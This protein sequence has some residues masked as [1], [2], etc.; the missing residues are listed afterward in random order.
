[1]SSL[2]RGVEFCS[3]SG[4]LDDTEYHSMISRLFAGFVRKDLIS[5]LFKQFVACND[6]SFERQ[7]CDNAMHQT[8]KIIRGRDNKHEQF[9][10]IQ[11][12]DLSNEMGLGCLSDDLYGEI[13]SYLKQKDY[14]AYSQTNRAIY[15]GCNS[16]N[17][18]RHLDL[19]KV[20]NYSSVDLSKYPQ[21]R[22]LKIK[23]PK[24]KELKLP[25]NGTSICNH[26]HKLTLDGNKQTDMDLTH[27]ISN[28]C[29]NFT[30]LTHL[31]LSKF[32]RS[33]RDL[34]ECLNVMIFRLIMVRFRMITDLSF[35]AVHC[36]TF[37]IGD[38]I[39]KSLLP[40]LHAFGCY[41]GEKIKY[42]PIAA[43]TILQ[44][45]RLYGDK[46][47]SLRF[48]NGRFLQG[49][50]T[51]ISFAGLRDLVVL[52][53][54]R[55][56]GEWVDVIL[57]TTKN[58][59]NVSLNETRRKYKHSLGGNWQIVVNEL[60]SHHSLRYLSI[61]TNI[62]NFVHIV[63]G[64]E[65]GLV[66]N[67]LKLSLDFNSGQLGCPKIFDYVSRILDAFLSLKGR[68]FMLR[69]R[70]F[71]GTVLDEIVWRAKRS[72]FIRVY[73]EC[74]DIQIKKYKFQIKNRNCKICGHQSPFHKLVY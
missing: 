13:G 30:N 35:H 6:G 52:D 5:W 16:P 45:V 41:F 50:P 26:L 1:M 7:L 17:F 63:N 38:K 72:D 66:S 9:Q 74:A 69:F 46:L 54:A 12:H 34:F 57:K 40:N 32:G 29:I 20:K 21:L 15:V 28:N 61:T 65:C 23:L 44:F 36:R 51:G 19:I 39:I 64:I 60:A 4:Q 53:C 68:E 18:L 33:G 11:N 24:F 56:Y 25:S 22:I 43:T 31:R 47:R 62:E 42:D 14:F 48:C 49:L 73:S 27:F 55:S 58:L 59:V 67:E 2:A 70:F 37:D 3:L 71:S 8:T 10:M